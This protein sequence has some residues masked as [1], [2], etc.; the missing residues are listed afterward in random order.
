MDAAHDADVPSAGLK[1]G[2]CRSSQHLPSLDILKNKRNSPVF[3]GHNTQNQPA[4]PW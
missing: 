2:D 3:I 1:A 4:I